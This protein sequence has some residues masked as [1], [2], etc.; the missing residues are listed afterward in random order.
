MTRCVRRKHAA[1]LEQTVE[2]RTRKLK[3]ME[4]DIRRGLFA[5]GQRLPG[6]AGQ[7]G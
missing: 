5:G 1:R 7:P 3:E 4:T 2:E 6:Q